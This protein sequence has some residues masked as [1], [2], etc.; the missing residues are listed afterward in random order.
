MQL[1]PYL[2]FNGNCED[3]MNFYKDA[4]NGE[5]IGI[6]RFGDSPMEVSENDKNRIMNV[7]FKA[8]DIAFMASD[9][10]PGQNGPT[11]SNITMALVTTNREETDR[12]FAA[13]SAGGQ[14]TM[15]LEVTFWNAYF[16]MFTDKFGISWMINCDLPT[17]A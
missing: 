12:T 14:V 9:T 15:P 5:I 10:M 8:G 6:S 3:A 17:P 4:L 11:S 7:E 13:L 2:T 16:G 1:Y